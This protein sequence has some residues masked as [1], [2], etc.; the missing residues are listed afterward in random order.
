MS[1][2]RMYADFSSDA[3]EAMTKGETMFKNGF[4]STEGSFY[5]EQPVF[6]EII[7]SEDNNGSPAGVMIAA[8]LVAVG[9]AVAYGISRREDIK[10]WVKEKAAPAI[11]DKFGITNNTETEPL[12]EK[13]QD[14]MSNIIDFETVVRNREEE[15]VRCVR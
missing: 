6:S 12:E 14:K 4:R 1:G 3:W 2:H 10:T 13:N 9:A 15:K 11:K 7:N 5:P 8:G